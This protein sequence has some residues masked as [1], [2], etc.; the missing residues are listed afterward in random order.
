MLN[1]KLH[2]ESSLSQKY[3]FWKHKGLQF[4]SGKTLKDATHL[5]N[6]GNW[7]LATSIRGAIICTAKHVL[8][9]VRHSNLIL[10]IHMYM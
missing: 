1:D 5:N 8:S 10:R 9:L 7:R 2:L 6:V 4:P 3:D